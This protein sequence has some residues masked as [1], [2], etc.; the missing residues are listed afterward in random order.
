MLAVRALLETGASPARRIVMLWTTDEELGS[1]TSREAI[2]DEARR[3]E[4]VLVLEPSLPGGA[5]KTSRKGCGQFELTVTGVAAHAGIDPGQGASAVHELAHQIIR[6]QALQDLARGVS[7]NVTQIQGGTRSNVIPDEARAVI[8][9][10]VPTMADAAGVEA[11]LQSLAPVD[12]RTT[13]RMSGGVDRPPLERNAGVARLYDQARQIA[14]ELGHDLAEGA[15]G[16]GSDGNFT[17]AL[18]VPTLDG[19]GAIGDGAHALHEHVE[20]DALPD[21][22]ALIAGLI[23]GLERISKV[24]QRFEKVPTNH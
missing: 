14:R 15:T 12:A 8:D 17:A 6:I 20:V 1:A 18:G 10:R 4:A 9:V 19:L 11:A 13:L 22:A 16:G 23:E 21:R 2:E 24:D 3:S 5:V 7:V